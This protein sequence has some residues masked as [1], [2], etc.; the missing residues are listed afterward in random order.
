M[1]A[2]VRWLYV[3]LVSGWPLL[4]A[5]GGS[6]GQ[7]RAQDR[8]DLPCTAFCREWM[9][10]PPAWARQPPA[11]TV[12]IPEP[13]VLRRP[14]VAR[15]KTPKPDHIAIRRPLRPEADRPD[16]TSVHLTDVPPR[17]DEAA[18][19][20]RPAPADRT[21]ARHSRWA[22]ISVLP[23]PRPA[24]GLPPEPVVAALP[25]PTTPAKA[26]LQR[27]QVVTAKPMAVPGIGSGPGTREVVPQ[28]VFLTND[29]VRRALVVS[30][31]PV[32]SKDYSPGDIVDA[33]IALED[34]PKTIA[35]ARSDLDDLKYFAADHG[36]VVLVMPL[37]RRVLHVLRASQ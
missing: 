18:T 28:A 35:S 15:R 33:D 4:L 22:T 19:Q 9:G 1:I 13:D 21:P 3:T 17:P 31:A 34:L 16:V 11:E 7:A 5:A 25:R 32:S 20:A 2:P 27:P 12:D 23:P 24:L 37:R 6:V 8:S 36:T 14:H 10:F 29:E 26:P 30:R